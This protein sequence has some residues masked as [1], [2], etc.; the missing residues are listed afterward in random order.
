FKHALTH[1]VVYGGLL[2]QR[3][4]E[5]HARVVEAI[6]RLYP[7]RL[8]EHV[9]RLGHHAV[10]GE[11]WEKAVRYLSQAGAKLFERSANQEAA[12][13][14]EQAIAALGRLPGNPDRVTESIDLR[15]DLRS[16]LHAL[17]QFDRI[18]E[19][20]RDAER[21][22]QRAN[23]QRRLGRVYGYLATNYTFSGEYGR[24]IESGRQARAIAEAVDDFGTQVV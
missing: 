14:F 16:A 24:A 3:R 13:W 5:L 21:L 11:V 2:Q 1:E 4:R 15:L 18:F 7:D 19:V 8:S 10:S 12:L 6:E 9:E 20:L 17:G 22:A 23:D